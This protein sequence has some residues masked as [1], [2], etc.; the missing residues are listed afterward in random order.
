[1]VNEQEFRRMVNVIYEDFSE[2]PA[3]WHFN[4]AI[5]ALSLKRGI[6]QRR[7]KECVSSLREGGRLVLV[8][9]MVYTDQTAPRGIEFCPSCHK[10][11]KLYNNIEI[12]RGRGKVDSYARFRHYKDGKDIWHTLFRNRNEIESWGELDPR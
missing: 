6:P 11:G 4:S 9:A 10:S 2:R 7:V 5:P 8:G 1:M 3:G 12:R